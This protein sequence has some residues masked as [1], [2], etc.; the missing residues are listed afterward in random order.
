MTQLIGIKDN[1]RTHLVLD[2]DFCLSFV[3]TKFEKV[4]EK[5]VIVLQTIFDETNCLI[6]MGSDSF[7]QN[8][9]KT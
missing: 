5:N 4:T 7:K 2:I 9:I 1:Y 3:G 6:S 8:I